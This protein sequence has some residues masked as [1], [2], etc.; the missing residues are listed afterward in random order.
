MKK[1]AGRFVASGGDWE[2]IKE[3]WDRRHRS[4]VQHYLSPATSGEKM[5]GFLNIKGKLSEGAEAL[6]IG[7]GSGRCTRDVIARGVRLSALDI[8][9][10]ALKKV[11]GLVVAGYL[12][13]TGLPSDTFDVVFSHLVSQHMSDEDLVIQVEQVLRALKPSGV[14]AMQFASGRKKG[15]SLL[16][17]QRG[18]VCRTLDDM[19]KLVAEVGG[20][21]AWAAKAR[22]VTPRTLW[23][24]VHIRRKGLRPR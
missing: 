6:E 23:Q 3:C 18:G 1:K 11:E 20:Q 15:Q 24:G 2:D 21:V 19:R 10:A 12:Q 17:Q 22:Q 13:A 9:P 7:V 16:M 14:F 5:W 4:G 8:S